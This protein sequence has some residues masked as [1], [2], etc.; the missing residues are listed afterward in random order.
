MLKQLIVSTT[1]IQLLRGTAADWVADD[2]RLR[3]GELGVEIDTGILKVGD[4]LSRFSQLAE[5]GDGGGGTPGPQG[6]PGPPGANGAPGQDGFSPYITLFHTNPFSTNGG[7]DSPVNLGMKFSSASDG[8]AIGVRFYKHPSNIGTHIGAIWDE[9]T[10]VKL[11]EVTFED[12]SS[13]GWQSATFDTPIYIN[14]AQT[15]IVS[16]HTTV[17]FFLVEAHDFDA[18]KTYSVI[19]AP[20]AAG[21]FYYNSGVAFPGGTLNNA[22]YYVDVMISAA[23]GPPGPQGDPTSDAELAAIAGLTSAADKLPYFTGSGTAALAD[24]TPAGRAL[25]DDAD[26]SAQR[27]TLGLGTAAMLASDTDTTLAANSDARLATQK[28]IKAYVDNAVTG[29]WDV[30]GSTDCSANPNYPSALKGDAYAVSVAGKIGGASG[31]S[32]DVG[33]VFVALLDNAGGTE[34]SVGTS[35]M[36]IEHNL[37][38][39]YVAGGTDVAVAD[40]GTGASTASG[41]R[42]NLGL[43]IGTDVQAHSAALDA[44]SGVN[45][46]DQTISLTGDVTGSG[47]SSF[48]ATIAAHAV[49]LAKM[50][51][52]AT[53]R[54]LGRTT[55]ST[56]DVEALTGTQATALLDAVVGDS[57]SGGTKGLVPAPA[58]GDAAAGKFLK[59]DGT[60][61]AP[62][63][64]SG[65]AGTAT[66]LQTARNIDGQAFD[67]T[68]NVTV[69]APGTHAA[70]GKTTPVDADEVPLV[71]S[72]ASNIL[73]KLTW[74]NVKATLK[75]YFDTLYGAGNALTANPLSQFA[76]TTSAQLAGVV[77]DKTG[78]G[79][80][81]FAN[82]PAIE[83]LSVLVNKSGGSDVSPLSVWKASANPSSSGSAVN[84]AFRVGI[85]GATTNA[86][87]FGL[88]SF[89]WIQARKSSDY[90][91]NIDLRIQPNGG[92]ITTSSACK[93]TT[94]S[95]VTAAPGG[96]AGEWKMGVATS[97]V[98]LALNTTSYIEVSI[99]GTVVKLAQVL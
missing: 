20:V 61:T 55:V 30:K 13:S 16:Y 37:T 38:G 28:A 59:A 79:A 51:Q 45:T 25:V 83:P 57:G 73:K 75:T 35:W 63:S 96:S 48:A 70:T 4:G 90:S 65:N 81:V 10:Q 41:A 15:Y 64:V 12:E 7:A 36:H 32:V 54:F 44:V 66:A 5:V 56:G 39:V 93:I 68:A 71:D 94:G 89:G 95:V 91:V 50:A 46:G 17:G 60:F 24:F 21:T 22:N 92:N 26:A 40:G 2:R 99:D 97:G 82:Q 69:I 84:G 62:S 85:T 3:D 52:V 42:T 6:D 80:L 72:A 9:D 43:G 14:A 29:L 77:S 87:D 67:G 8:L 18:P 31:A 78:S 47:T 88:S 74:A 23:V 86:I 11:A 34:A 19:T 53:A 58:S 49:T 1:G 27:T 33:D 98:A 76:A